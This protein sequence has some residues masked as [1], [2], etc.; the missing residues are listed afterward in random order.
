MCPRPALVFLFQTLGHLP[1]R[2][3]PSHSKAYVNKNSEVIVDPFQDTDT[4]PPPR[5]VINKGGHFQRNITSAHY[6]KIYSDVIKITHR[7]F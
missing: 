1:A 2:P 6:I 7:T 5:T 4:P 3:V